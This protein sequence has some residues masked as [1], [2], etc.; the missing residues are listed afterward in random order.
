MTKDQKKELLD[1]LY[2]QYNT[3]SF[4]EADPISIPHSFAKA[5]DI[6]ISGFLAA[7]IAWGNRRMIVGNAW[8]LMA[9]MDNAPYD[10]V[11][12]AEASDLCA[13][14]RFVHR[15]F[16]GCDCAYFISALQNLYKNHG[17]LG[18]FFQSQYADTQDLRVALSRFRQVFFE[19][20]HE[21]RNEKHISSIDK[22]AAC[23]RLCMYLKWMV[24]RDDRG[25]DFGLW[26]T[27]PAS[28]LYLP[29]DV[30]TA[31][32]GRELGLLTR[33]QNDWRAVEEITASL[34]EFD[35]EDPVKYD[36]A[37]FGVGVN[38]GK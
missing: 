9:I 2:D 4:I 16:Q 18:G 20:P 25:V 33:T 8:R 14:E 29:L 30:H 21:T 36:F 28:A 15:T 12:N 26:D 11:K 31:R 5:E 37:L 38:K 17:G 35:A 22:G 23:K 27:I 7:T 3:E 24:R 1:Y 34:R 13:V 32:E 6:E 10:F 19:L